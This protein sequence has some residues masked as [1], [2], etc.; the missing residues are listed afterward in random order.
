MRALWL[1]GFVVACNGGSAQVVPDAPPTID[2]AVDAQTF[3]CGAGT[4]ESSGVCI[5]A[6]TRYA[7]RIGELSIGANGRTK[8]KVVVF[9][10]KPDGSPVLDRVV[11]T[12]SRPNAGTL[13][14]SALNLTTLGAYTYF[15]PCDSASAGCLGPVTLS[16]ALASAPATTIAQ[17]D[18]SI[19]TPTNVS[20]IAP[21]LEDNKVLWV[22][23]QGGILQTLWTVF[24]GSWFA[25]TYSNAINI[26]VDAED[27][28][29]STWLVEVNSRFVGVPL[30]PGTIFEN[31]R[32]PSSQLDGYP[33]LGVTGNSYGCNTVD[34]RFQIHTYTRSPV[35]ILVSFEQKCDGSSLVLEGCVR[36]KP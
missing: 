31:A 4:I 8:R 26:V 35:D 9:G 7:I 27:E 12:M 21:C 30:T 22:D 17:I 13:R 18:A 2:A 36:Y 20:S 24:A 33:A 16:V 29:L 23:G 1:I 32:K 10:T 19:V 6:A 11:I 15:V 28:N 14:E 34:G 3:T 25:D 5:P